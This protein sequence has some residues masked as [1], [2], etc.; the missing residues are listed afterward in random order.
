MP[1]FYAEGAYRGT[2]IE[3]GFGQSKE[4]K[5]HF[6]FLKVKI[7]ADEN[8]Q[9]VEKSYERTVTRYIT[10]ATVEY[11][12]KDLKALGFEWRDSFNDL[13]P[14][15]PSHHSFVGQ[16]VDLYCKHEGEYEK[17]QISR[18]M[19]GGQQVEQLGSA[20]MRKLDNMFGRAM[21]GGATPATPRSAPARQAQPVAAG[22]ISDDDVPF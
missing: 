12:A 17:W 8:G 2:V 9:P 19:G 15:V 22:G 5:T 10:E 11:F 13:H 1:Q 21:K 14:A 7:E 3:Q 18:P 6:F 20:E 16:S 4:K